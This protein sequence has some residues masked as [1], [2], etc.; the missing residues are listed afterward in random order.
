[1]AF[2]ETED[3]LKAIG[4]FGGNCPWINSCRRNLPGDECELALTCEANDPS[5]LEHTKTISLPLRPQNPTQE[6]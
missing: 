4:A 5:K 2:C 6:N 3:R 1:M